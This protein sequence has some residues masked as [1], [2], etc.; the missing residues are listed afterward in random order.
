MEL[1]NSFAIRV[2]GT[3]VIIIVAIIHYHCFQPPFSVEFSSASFAQDAYFETE[4]LHQKHDASIVYLEA[5]TL[6]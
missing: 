1:C 6:M 3:M 2:G 5:E 4:R